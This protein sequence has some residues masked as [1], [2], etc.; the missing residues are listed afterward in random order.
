MSKKW[1]E[2]SNNYTPPSGKVNDEILKEIKHF[3][4]EAKPISPETKFNSDE[5]NN[6]VLSRK[7]LS[8]K[9]KWPRFPPEVL[10]S[11]KKDDK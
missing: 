3:E 4:K 11:L 10:E 7:V 9:G 2:N 5:V 8:K 1:R 6:M